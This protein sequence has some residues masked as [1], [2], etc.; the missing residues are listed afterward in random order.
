MTE[1]QKKLID[2]VENCRKDM[3]E[4]E[5]AKLKPYE[6][7][8]KELKKEINNYKLAEIEAKDIMAELEEKL[9]NADYQLEGRDLEIKELKAQIEKMKNWCNCGNYQDCLI[10]RAEEGKGLKAEECHNCNKW[11]LQE[12]KNRS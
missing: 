2:E 7:K 1:R 11:R 5:R 10:Q 4:K 9:A 12:K 6:D 8:I 3:Q